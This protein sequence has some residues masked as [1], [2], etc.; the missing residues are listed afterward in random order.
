MKTIEGIKIFNLDLRSLCK[1]LK[2]MLILIILFEILV[3]IT[4]DLIDIYYSI[5]TNISILI[6]IIIEVKMN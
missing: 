3:H 5:N 6:W 1:L 2:V 4:E